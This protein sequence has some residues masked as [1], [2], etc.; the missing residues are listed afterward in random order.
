MELQDLDELIQEYFGY[1]AVYLGYDEYND[2]SFYMLYDSFVVSFA[3]DDRYRP[4]GASIKFPNN[5]ADTYFLGFNCCLREHSES[6]IRNDLP[7]IDK[8][9]RMRLPSLFLK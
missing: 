2:G 6:V 9:C 5:M 3:F 4:F 1:K 7:K 8:Y